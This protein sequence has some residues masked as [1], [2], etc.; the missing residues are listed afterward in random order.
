MGQASSTASCAAKVYFS[1]SVANQPAVH[2][3]CNRSGKLQHTSLIRNIVEQ[4]QVLR[5]PLEKSGITIPRSVAKVRLDVLR[6]H[7]H[8]DYALGGL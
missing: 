6:G 8:I 4:A 2:P 5:F 1:R 3:T 7:V